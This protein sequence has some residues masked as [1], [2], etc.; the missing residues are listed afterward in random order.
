[1]SPEYIE[2]RLKNA[3]KTIKSFQHEITSFQNSQSIYKDLPEKHASLSKDLEL[4]KS[5]L[6]EFMKSLNDVVQKIK[7]DSTEL[8][9]SGK[10]IQL[11]I[12]EFKQNQKGVTDTIQTIFPKFPPIENKIDSMKDHENEI[13]LLKNEIA[14][15][16]EK[17]ENLKNSFENYQSANQRVLETQNVGINDVRLLSNSVNDTQVKLVNDYKKNMQILEPYLKTKAKK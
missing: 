8:Q 9:E 11:S 5:Q 14:K 7:K 17:L 12:N 15:T 2:A 4:I 13:H 6:Q 10:I 3:E 1:M 16:N